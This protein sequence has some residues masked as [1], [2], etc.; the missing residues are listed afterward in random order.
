MSGVG[1]AVGFGVGVTADLMPTFPL[2]SEQFGGL[3]T[4]TLLTSPG[5]SS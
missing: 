4:G 2:V 3:T 1:V 5:V